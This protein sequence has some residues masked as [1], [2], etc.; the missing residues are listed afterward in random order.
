MNWDSMDGLHDPVSENRAL[1][2]LEA[3][4]HGLELTRSPSGA[5]QTSL[6]IIQN[7]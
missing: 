4:S 1:L 5:S 6:S 2:L 7:A 3:K